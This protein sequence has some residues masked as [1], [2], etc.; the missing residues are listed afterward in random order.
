MNQETSLGNCE[1]RILFSSDG[2]IS[3]RVVGTVTPTMYLAAKGYLEDE[4]MATRFRA[5]TESSMKVLEIQKQLVEVFQTFVEELHEHRTRNCSC[6]SDIP[7]LLP[8]LPQSSSESE[9]VDE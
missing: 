7:V 4:A 8:S 2:K 1:I 5:V 9:E 6:H 3:H